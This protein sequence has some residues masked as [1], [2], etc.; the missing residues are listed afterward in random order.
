MFFPL[1]KKS[2]FIMQWKDM[3]RFSAPWLFFNIEVSQWKDPALFSSHYQ[4]CAL[5]WQNSCMASSGQAPLTPLHTAAFC[6]CLWTR[7]NYTSAGNY[8]RGVR[9][10]KEAHADPEVGLSDFSRKPGGPG[11]RDVVWE[12]SIG[13]CFSLASWTPCSMGEELSQ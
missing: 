10:R 1:K 9:F 11:F 3:F 2:K 6:Q 7:V 8:S 5:T 13:W 12:G 4:L